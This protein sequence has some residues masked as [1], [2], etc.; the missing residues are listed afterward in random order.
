MGSASFFDVKIFE[1]AFLGD[2]GGVVAALSQG[3][4]VYVRNHQGISPLWAAAQRGHAEICC[5][6]LAHGGSVKDWGPKGL[7]PLLVAAD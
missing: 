4:S 1:A 5:L 2:L 7:T 6:L 3:G